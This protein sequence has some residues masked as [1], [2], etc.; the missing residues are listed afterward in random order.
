MSTGRGL[1]ERALPHIGEPY[2]NV[3]VPKNNPNWHGPWD[4]AEF[5]SWLVFQESGIL[6]GCTNDHANPATADAYTGAW[7]DDS[8]TLGKRVSVDEAAA[9]VGAILLRYP[10]QAGT[11]GHVVLCDGT[12]GTVEAMDHQHGVARG[13]VH[14][15]RWDTGVLIPNF[16]YDPPGRRIAVQAPKKLLSLTAKKANPKTVRDIQQAL[17]HRNIDPGPLDGVYGDKTAAAVA[18]F[19]KTE[20]L[21]V[22]GEVGAQTAAKLKVKL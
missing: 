4:C 6:Y 8:A 15:R 21:V 1:L 19:Q 2:E 3:L 10:P 22:D 12:G 20:G 16:Y 11:M 14:N 18:A 9:T 17:Y 5:M 7:R 13:T